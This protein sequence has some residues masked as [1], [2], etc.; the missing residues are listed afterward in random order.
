MSSQSNAVNLSAN[1]SVAQRPVGQT[2]TDEMGRLFQYCKANGAITAGRWEIISTDG[3]YTATPATTALCGTPGTHWKEIGVA[4]ASLTDAY[5]GW[6]WRGYGAYTAIIENGFAATDVL[7]TTANAGIPGTNSSS[8]VFDGVKT[9]AAGV[10][11]TLVSVYAAGRI[12][13]GVTMAHD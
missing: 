11:S 8:F 1:D 5:F 9:I 10:T 4:C 2:Y 3:L 12:T 6:F 7:Y 13:A